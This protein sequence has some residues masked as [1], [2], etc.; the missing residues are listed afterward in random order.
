[1]RDLHPLA[2][3]GGGRRKREKKKRGVL[4][5]TH[6]SAPSFDFPPFFVGLWWL[7][8]RRNHNFAA[9]VVLNSFGFLGGTWTIL[10]TGLV[11][12]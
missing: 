11:D 2:E 9:L 3:K 6:P 5:Y 4:L 10:R 8:D 1:M 12:I 7:T